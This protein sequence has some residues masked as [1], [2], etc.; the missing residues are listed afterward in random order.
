MCRLHEDLEYLGRLSRGHAS[1]YWK[2]GLCQP[3][4]Y[5]GLG[6]HHWGVCSHRLR[7]RYRA[8]GLNR[9]SDRSDDKQ[10][11]GGCR[12]GWPCMNPTQVDVFDDALRGRREHRP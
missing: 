1:N 2:R 12:W 9:W 6:D 7:E 4:E 8:L 11:A 3:R 10:H 5:W